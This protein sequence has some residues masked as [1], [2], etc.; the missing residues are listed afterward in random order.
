MIKVMEQTNI[1]SFLIFSKEKNTALLSMV[2]L[3]KM[4][5]ESKQEGMDKLK[6]K[7]ILQNNWPVCIK[8]MSSS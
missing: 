6:L 1:I 3:R 7:D 4:H 2:F 5:S 8:K